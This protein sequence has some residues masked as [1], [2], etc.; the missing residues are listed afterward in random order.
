[1]VQLSMPV[2]DSLAIGLSIFIIGY[3]HAVV[4]LM[5]D[6]T[7]KHMMAQRDIGINRPQ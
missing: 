2:L 3:P 7:M 5:S 6:S 1:M 4:L